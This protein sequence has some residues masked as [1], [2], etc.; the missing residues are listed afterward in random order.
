MRAAL[1]ALGLLMIGVAANAETD[2][3]AIG[4]LNRDGKFAL[5]EAASRTMLRGLEA[6]GES[7]SMPAAEALDELAIALRRGGKASDPDALKACEQAL[8]ALP[9]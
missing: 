1:F 8:R 4:R 5:A 7:E 9:R 6:R 2:L 3:E